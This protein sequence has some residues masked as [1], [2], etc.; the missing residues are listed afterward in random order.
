MLLVQFMAHSLTGRG[1]GLWLKGAEKHSTWT[2]SN[3]ECVPSLVPRALPASGFQPQL[4]SCSPLMIG[5]YYSQ[6]EEAMEKAV[7]E[8]KPHI[9]PSTWHQ[10]MHFG[11]TARAHPILGTNTCLGMNPPSCSSKHQACLPRD[12]HNFSHGQSSQNCC[13]YS[14]CLHKGRAASPTSLKSLRWTHKNLCASASSSP[15]INMTSSPKRST[16]SPG[17][18][19]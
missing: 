2:W 17:G 12:P 4:S 5:L 11:K 1:R 14:S 9:S 15:R 16:Q 18:N 6:L 7:L 13:K 19:I 3:K 10:W 8:G